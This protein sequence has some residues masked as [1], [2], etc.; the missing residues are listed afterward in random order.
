MVPD[1]QPGGEVHPDNHL[2]SVRLAFV[3]KK[4]GNSVPP[5]HSGEP[6]GGTLSRFRARSSHAASL[7][8]G[9]PSFQRRLPL[10]GAPLFA[11][12]SPLFGPNSPLWASSSP[13]FAGAEVLRRRARGRQRTIKGDHLVYHPV[14]GRRL[15]LGQQIARGVALVMGEVSGHP[16]VLVRVHSECLTGDVF[17]SLRCD[18]GAQLDAALAAVAREGRGVVVYLRGHEGAR[19]RADQQDARVQAAG[20]RPRHRRGQRDSWASGGLPQLRRR[21]ADPHRSG[22]HHAPSHEQQ[23][24]QFAEIEGYD[25]RIVGRVPLVVTPTRRT[26][27]TSARSSSSS[28]TSSTWLEAPPAGSA[29][30]EETA[31]ERQAGDHGTDRDDYWK[32]LGELAHRADRR[33]CRRQ[34]ARGRVG[35]GIDRRA[36]STAGRPAAREGRTRGRSLGLWVSSN[37]RT[38]SSWRRLSTRRRTPAF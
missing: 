21:R 25:L 30:N 5:T 34:P 7:R 33:G 29:G 23:S 2:R 9:Q 14:G 24:R 10:R 27:L 1:D 35:G 36:R 20:P 22:D 6:L 17:G 19:H 3:T 12:R 4:G 26:C 15:L 32:S 31:S 11:A 37:A 28:V 16:E 18:C 38:A 8:A 13:L